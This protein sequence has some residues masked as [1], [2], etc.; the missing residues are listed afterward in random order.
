MKDF[1]VSLFALAMASTSFAQ[2][3][4]WVN[5]AG[6]NIEAEIG[7]TRMDFGTTPPW[8]VLDAIKEHCS[9]TGCASGE[10]IDV[11]TILVEGGFGGDTRVKMDVSGTF[12]NVGQPGDKNQLVEIAKAI[13]ASNHGFEA[14]QP[15]QPGACIVT[16]DGCR[17][18]EDLI[19]VDQY[20]GTKSVI[21]RWEDDDGNLISFL[22]VGFSLP[23]A[24]EQDGICAGIIGIAGAI[25]A[26]VQPLTGGLFALLSIGCLGLKKPE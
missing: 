1:I 11:G 5:P 26:A 22:N 3:T 25:A 4:P 16:R 15:Y 12:N 20:T 18:N 21:V 17:Y 24:M 13:V 2:D 6:G 23:D 9:N 14:A 7:D 8:M 19:R 10:S